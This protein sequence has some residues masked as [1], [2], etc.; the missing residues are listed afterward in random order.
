V[1]KHGVGRILA[2]GFSFFLASFA[3]MITLVLVGGRWTA[4]EMSG[5]AWGDGTLD[6]VFGFLGPVTFVFTVAPALA[7]LP[8]VLVVVVG[9]VLRIRSALYYVAASGAAAVGMLIAAAPYEGGAPLLL[10]SQY[11]A[12]LATAGF[13]AGFVYWAFAGRNA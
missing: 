11:V 1:I 4:D 3:G 6:F 5:G 10:H 8:P 2:V 7:L 12:V 9:E 13:A